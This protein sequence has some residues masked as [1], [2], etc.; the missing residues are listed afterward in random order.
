MLKN[1]VMRALPFGILMLAGCTATPHQVATRGA[2]GHDVGVTSPGYVA[3]KS[4]DYDT[5]TRLLE[6]ANI[7]WPNSP[8][9]EL[10][11]G[12]SYQAQG[13]MDLAEPFLRRAMTHGHGL[14]P[15]E[16]TQDWARGMTV[17]EAACQNLA[18]GLAPAT[19][20]GT[21]TPCQTTLVVAVIAAPG[22][23]AAVYQQTTYN[24]YFDFDKATLTK[25]GEITM[26]DAAREIRSDP[27]RRIT[28]IGKASSPGTDYYNMALSQQRVE[29]VRNAL[30]AAGVPSSRIEVRWVGERE[31]PVPRRD[32]VREPL[33][34]VVEGTVK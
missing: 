16:S 6:A 5:S 27:A 11:L 18:I 4:G 20:E 28:L 25:D 12:A 8:Y 21:A 10:N 13:R 26:R 2:P 9:D 7:K 30:V 15:V 1:T 32:G 24:T 29:T 22:P 19:V 31:L 34:R 14:M 33:N 23:V 3:L 17:E